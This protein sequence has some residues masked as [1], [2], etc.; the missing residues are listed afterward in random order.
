MSDR[1]HIMIAEPSSIIRYGLSFILQQ[2]RVHIACDIIEVRDVATLLSSTDSSDITPDILIINPSNIGLSSSATLKG[3]LRNENLKIVALQSGLIEQ[4]LLK[5]FDA[6]ISIYDTAEKITEKIE[7]L[8]KTEREV[9][10]KKG[11]LSAREKEIVVC[12]VK[13]LTNRQIADALFLSTHTVIAHRRN[14]ANKLQIHSPSGLTIYA[15]VNKLV[16]LS[17]IQQSISQGRDEE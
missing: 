9:E 12:V 8:I 5:N 17:E 16:D 15:I 13:G 2:A 6:A 10:P 14:I 1:V 7:R 11:E 4:S 3:N